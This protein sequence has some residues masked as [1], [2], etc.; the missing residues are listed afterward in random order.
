MADVRRYGD[1]SAQEKFRLGLVEAEKLIEHLRGASSSL[2]IVEDAMRSCVEAGVM[3]I[4]SDTRKALVTVDGAISLAVSKSKWFK[5]EFDSTPAQVI[6]GPPKFRPAKFD[7]DSDEAEIARI[8]L[9]A[10][11]AVTDCSTRISKVAH[12]KAGDRYSAAVQ[13]AWKAI[14][15]QLAPL[16]IGPE[17]PQETN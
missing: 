7:P 3:R 6:D 15:D 2:R 13:A 16:L 8:L 4:Q 17:E 5:V 12:G 11:R 1:L 9:E 14:N 10:L